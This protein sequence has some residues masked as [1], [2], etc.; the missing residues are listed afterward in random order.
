[1]KLEFLDS[2]TESRMFKNSRDF[3][4]MSNRTLANISMIA[5]IICTIYRQ[6]SF[7]RNYLENTIGFG[8]FDFV[9]SSSTDLANVIS[10]LKNFKEYK[11]LIANDGISF[12][13]LQ[14]KSFARGIINGDL[15][16]ADYRRYLYAFEGFLKIND[17]IIRNA[18]RFAYD[19]EQLD[20][21]QRDAIQ[22]YFVNYLNSHAYTMDLTVWYK[23]EI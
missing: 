11:I 5:I 7:V 6:N 13:I 21:V 8:D 3:S 9:R 14:F 23:K 2:L 1:M 4:S 20:R 15:S 19:W 10:V 18:R 16:E 12:P 22:R 17:G